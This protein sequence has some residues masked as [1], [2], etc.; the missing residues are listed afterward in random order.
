MAI[1]TEEPIELIKNVTDL[2]K[3]Q[4]IFNT[5]EKYDF[6]VWFKI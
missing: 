6:L 5:A 3:N 4:D 1:N 2:I